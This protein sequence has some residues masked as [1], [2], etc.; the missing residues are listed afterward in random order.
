MRPR[1][2]AILTLTACA[3]VLAVG[4]CSDGQSDEATTVTVTHPPVTPV[5]TIPG[6][7]DGV[8]T[9]RLFHADA[10]FEDIGSGS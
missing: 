1:P 4:A 10:T 6:A 8:G 2:L 9:L 3:V 7:A 5:G